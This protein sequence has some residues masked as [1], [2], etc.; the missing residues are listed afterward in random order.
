MFAIAKLLRVSTSAIVTQECV[1]AS[2]AQPCVCIVHETAWGALESTR[3]TFH[4]L[5]A[6][7]AAAPAC[8]ELVC[9]R[10]FLSIVST[11]S[12]SYRSFG[13][14]LVFSSEYTSSHV[15]RTALTFASDTA[16]ATE[17]AEAPSL[18]AAIFVFICEMYF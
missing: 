18:A 14:I 2:P 5:G 4:F 13:L 12:P 1:C 10:M 15:S 8:V 17:A 16:A 6:A 3:C 7:A 11:S 9:L